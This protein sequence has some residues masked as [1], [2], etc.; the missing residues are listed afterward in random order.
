MNKSRL[1]ILTLFLLYLSATVT[2]QQ[3]TRFRSGI[4]LHHSTGGCIWGPNG[5]ST[6][7]PQE[8]A[9]FNLSHGYT[10]S[11]AV[12]MQELGWP[13]NP[14]NNEWER[15][16]RIF[17]D[18]DTIEADIRP[19]YSPN[20]IIVIKSCFPSSSMSE[21][22]SASDTLNPTSKSVYNYKWHWR[23]IISV[24][25]DHPN[26]YFAIWTN[27]PLVAN[28]TNDSEASLSD[29]FCRWAKDTLATGNDLL[30]GTFPPNVFVFDYF[31][32]LADLSGKLPAAYAASS[33]DSHPNS[34][35]TELVA[36]L[37]VQEIFNSAIS[38][39]PETVIAPPALFY[40]PDKSVNLPDS[41]QF[42]WEKKS[43]ATY[44]HLQLSLDSLFSM[45][46]YND[47]L[48]TD[49][50]SR[51]GILNNNQTYYWHVKARNQISSS[52][53]SDIWKVTIAAEG[54][55]QIYVLKGWNMMSLPLRSDSL[56]FNQIFPTAISK[57]FIYREGLNYIDYNDSL[58]PG[59][60]F[61]LKFGYD[62]I[63]QIAGDIVFS[64]TID[65]YAGWNMIGSLSESISVN[66]I[67]TIPDDLIYPDIFGYENGYY[68][69]DSMKP[70]RGF[71]LKAKGNGK[72]ILQSILK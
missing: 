69:T 57:A 51:I 32:K 56:S 36:P 68:I 46:E 31:H 49:T 72:V 37:F 3:R 43:G 41:I 9:S 71:W 33:S 38:Y 17:E 34:A 14:W 66:S 13:V 28:A 12:S 30:F 60:G 47:S 10:D 53:W 26:N 23:H 24:M 4:F 65:V 1:L 16:H 42:I 58:K 40:P 70:G 64:D 35:A 6:S 55:Y 15:W 22:G 7:I 19:F 21:W 67:L 52:E 25:R 45:I 29:K 8:I 27:A 18:E 63:V 54:G 20:P 11:N 39:E 5:S 44:Y 61:W 59:D 48:L 62:Q 2:A 50:S